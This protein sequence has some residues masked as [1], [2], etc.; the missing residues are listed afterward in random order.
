MLQEYS[1]GAHTTNKIG[2][3]Q[4]K[5]TKLNNPYQGDDEALDLQL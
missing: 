3:M 1:R 2:S 4:Q 5:T